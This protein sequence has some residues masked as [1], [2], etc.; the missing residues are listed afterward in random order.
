MRRTVR[1]LEVA[2]QPVVA[3]RSAYTQAFE[4]LKRLRA[5]AGGVVE[6]DLDTRELRLLQ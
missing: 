4:I 6:C 5:A 1:G 3:W 2:D